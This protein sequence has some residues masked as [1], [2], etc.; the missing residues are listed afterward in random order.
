MSILPWYTMNDDDLEIERLVEMTRRLRT[1]RAFIDRFMTR[2]DALRVE[3]GL[4][5]RGPD[6]YY[7][8]DLADM[9]QADWWLRSS[10]YSEALSHEFGKAAVTALRAQGLDARLNVVGHVAIAVP[11]E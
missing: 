2:S 10:R 1:D 6:G 8:S 11:V 5:P 4:I 9:S 7:V 3:T